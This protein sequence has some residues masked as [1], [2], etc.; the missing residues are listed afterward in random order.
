MGLTVAGLAASGHHLPHQDINFVA[1]FA[2]VVFFSEA[3]ALVGLVSAALIRNMLAAAA[4]L[5]IV[6]NTVEGLLSLVLKQNSVYMPFTALSQVVQ[7]PVLQGAVAA[8]P[9]ASTGY[10]SAPRGALVFMAYL[11]V[12]WLITW[13]VFVHR[14]AN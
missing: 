13:Y 12:A 4:V 1:F 2:K 10:L 3:Y 9:D 6:P 11:V 5:L 8:H 7:P 14:D